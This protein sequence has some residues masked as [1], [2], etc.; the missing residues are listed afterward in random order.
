[1]VVCSASQYRLLGPEY[2]YGGP[3][4]VGIWPKKLSRSGSGGLEADGIAQKTHRFG[5]MV[6]DLVRGHFHGE[7]DF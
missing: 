5:V 7:S 3:R 2:A 4:I 6:F 1:M